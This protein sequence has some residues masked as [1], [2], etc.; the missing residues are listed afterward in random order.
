M[1]KTSLK[2][3]EELPHGEFLVINSIR[4]KSNLLHDAERCVKTQLL[5]LTVSTYQLKAIGKSHFDW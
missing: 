4:E 5:C 1:E 2:L 3:P